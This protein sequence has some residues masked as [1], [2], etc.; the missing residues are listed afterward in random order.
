MRKE[1]AFKNRGRFIPA[2]TALETTLKDK[3]DEVDNEWK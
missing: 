3:L 1:V 2:F